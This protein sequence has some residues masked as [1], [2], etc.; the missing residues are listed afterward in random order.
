MLSSI[1]GFLTD[2]AW[3]I[4]ITAL[5]SGLGVFGSAYM[6]W[7]KVVKEALE[8]G[9]AVFDAVGAKGPDGRKINEKEMARIIDEADD[10]YPV[11]VKAI[12]ATKAKKGK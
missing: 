4:V 6:L 5:V 7:G 3:T 12:A 1:A 2:Q 11:L 8:F 9:K 10:L